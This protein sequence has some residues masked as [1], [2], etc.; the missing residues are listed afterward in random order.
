M[1]LNSVI[2]AGEPVTVSVEH[3][4]RYN[5]P[6]GSNDHKV[7][8]AEVAVYANG[9]LTGT[10][11][12][13]KEG[14]EIRI[15]AESEIYGR[16]E[17]TVKVPH[18]V[19]I[20]NVDFISSV[21]AA[22]CDEQEGFTADLRFNF[23]ARLMISDGTSDDEYFRLGYSPYSQEWIEDENQN[24]QD[25]DEDLTGYSSYLS[26]GILDYNSDPIFSEHIGI[27]ESML[28][29]NEN[30]WL[31]FTDRM[32]SGRDYTMTL[33]FDDAWF[34]ASGPEFD[35]T[36]FDCSI[37]FELMSISRSYYDRMNYLWQKNSG[38]IGELSEIGLANPV[39]GYSNVSTGAGVVVARPLSTYRLPLKD[40]LL[41]A[42]EGSESTQVR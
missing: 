27:V 29:G 38:M 21:S 5:D 42:L 34:S 31:F 35:E 33:R 39:C 10:G 16:A 17:A 9:E 6:N 25:L 14:D 7:E 3:T 12:L 20:E 13:A 23:E 30:L 26:P 4:W 41:D 2:I 37:T 18:A 15:V 22:W 36:L 19:S 1:C 32:F 8:D 28:G 11:Y 24:K 40:F